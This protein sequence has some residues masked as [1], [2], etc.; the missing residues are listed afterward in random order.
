MLRVT[1]ALLLVACAATPARARDKVAVGSFRVAG[2]ALTEPVRAALRASALAALQ[3]AGFDPVSDEET[4]RAAAPDL[5]G[6]GTATCLRRLAER[7]GARHMVNVDI[8]LVGTSN[9]VIAFALV[10]AADGRSVARS[11]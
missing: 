4:A 11:D 1:A 7:L 2:E 5:T 3:A 9:Y 6:C 10:D 8:Q